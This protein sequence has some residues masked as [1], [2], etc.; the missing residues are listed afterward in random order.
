MRIKI[1][2]ILLLLILIT[3]ATPKILVAED[4]TLYLVEIVLILLIPYFIYIYDKILKYKVSMFLFLMWLIILISTILSQVAYPN[5]ADLARV[6]K[7][8]LYIP[9]IYIG[10]KHLNLRYMKFQ[11]YV[12]IAAMIL[13][14]IVMIVNIRIY[15][16]NIWDVK[17]IN[18]GLSNRFLD[19][20]NLEIGTIPSGAHGI[21]GNYCILILV[22]S[23]F[24]YRFKIVSEKLLITVA[25]LVLIN[26]GVSVSRESFLVL[27]CVMLIVFIILSYRL[28]MYYRISKLAIKL[29][30]LAICSTFVILLYLSEYIPIVNKITYTIESIGKSGSESNIQLRINA[31]IALLKSFSKYPHEILIG[32]GFNS[33]NYSYKLNHLRFINNFDFVALPES[34]FVTALGY[35][36]IFALFFSILFFVQIFK[37]T[38]GIDDWKSKYLFFA[39]F[40]GV[41]IVNIFSGASIISDLFY[42][43]IL[44][45]IGFIIKF[46]GNT[47]AQNSS[48]N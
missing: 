33:D 30:A 35:G 27:T 15:G 34:F 7:G 36:G 2:K 37:I 46:N 11:V 20:G 3:P 17:T 29:F 38:L 47:R 26:I 8:L 22:I 24:L 31:W 42:G 18:S 9:I 40:L 14:L 28:V 4:V 43:Q 19:L 32:Y 12:G 44:L 23:L 5:I 10:Y 41:L 16:F 48:N 39:F 1:L 21:W 45:V 13:S 6:F 25:G